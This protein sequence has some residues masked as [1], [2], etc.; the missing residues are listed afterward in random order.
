MEYYARCTKLVQH[1]DEKHPLPAEAPDAW[2]R[3]RVYPGDTFKGHT[4]QLPTVGKEF[5]IGILRTTEVKSIYEHDGIAGNDKL[6]LPAGFPNATKLVMP[7][8]KSG[9][10]LFATLNSIY[11]LTDITRI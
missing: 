8:V 5:F 3:G 2:F 10:M 4:E 11:H 7:E 1:D 9:D 6:V